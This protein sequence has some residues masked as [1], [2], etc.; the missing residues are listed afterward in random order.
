MKVRI[1]E[2]LQKNLV[3]IILLLF[4]S[5]N[6]TPPRLCFLYIF[7]KKFGPSQSDSQWPDTVTVQPAE[8]LRVRK[9][10]VF[11]RID[12]SSVFLYNVFCLNSNN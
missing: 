4:H 10:C 12:I 1:S 8:L 9:Q 3:P 11:L 5:F 6:K 2:L 7:R